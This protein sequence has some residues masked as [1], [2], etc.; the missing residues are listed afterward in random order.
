M[1]G[2]SPAFLRTHS[3][4]PRTLTGKRSVMT[5]WANTQ[6]NKML[7]S[8]HV[9][10]RFFAFAWFFHT[11]N[12][13]G[14]EDSR[15]KGRWDYFVSFPP[16]PDTTNL[17]SKREP[18][19]IGVC[20]LLVINCNFGKVL[21][22]LNFIFFFTESLEPRQLDPGGTLKNSEAP[23]V[24]LCLLGILFLSFVHG[25]AFISPLLYLNTCGVIHS[26]IVL[27]CRLPSPDDV[28][29]LG[30]LKLRNLWV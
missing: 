18:L 13:E 7:W 14:S 22:F 17:C 30:S 5:E 2:T 11:N 8:P 9:A 24:L 1:T 3:F 27:K 20:Y 6:A 23:S 26:K 25:V 4:G 15:S 28:L 21:T 29:V 16:P 12:Q 19:G 10:L